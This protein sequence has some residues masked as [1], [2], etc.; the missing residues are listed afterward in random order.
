MTPTAVYDVV[1]LPAA[2]VGDILA[3]VTG[4]W[5]EAHWVVGVAWAI[6]VEGC[7]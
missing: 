1:C 7:A 6:P 4:I 5:P 2:M 3:W